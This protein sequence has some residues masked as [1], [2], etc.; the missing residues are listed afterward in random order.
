MSNSSK[1]QARMALQNIE[2]YSPGKPIWEV[3][4]ELG[5]TEVIKLASNENPLG[6]SPKAIQAA[7]ASL[8]DMHRYPDAQAYDL[9]HA[10]ADKLAMQSEQIIVTNGGDEL[11]TLLSEAYLEQGDEVIVP[12]PSF[13]EYEFGALLMGAATV[14]VPLQEGFQYDWRSIADA[15]TERTKIVYLCSPN[16][17]TGTYLTRTDLQQLLDRLPARVLVVMDAAYSHYVSASDYSD[18]L[19]FVRAGYP[20]LVLKTFS[21]IYGLAGIRV[22]F[23]VAGQDMIRNILQVKEPFNVN[24]MAQTAAISALDDEE[25]VRQSQ[26]L[27]IRERLRLYE[28]FRRL[29]LPYTVSMSNFVL[30]ELG[31]DAESLYQ[32]LMAGGVIVRYGKGWGLPK[33]IRV[34]IGTAAENDTFISVLQG[35][36]AASSR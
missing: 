33:H 32:R 5:L 14:K 4:R 17:P 28:A 2:P 25:H 34:S 15:V 3:Q 1:V 36:L 18:G 29:G 11:I 12:D 19:E 20:V 24:A 23:G 10:I 21:K 6:T 13:T 7:A 30:V 22:G 35:V 8:H 26:E 27:V 16:N 31:P 9:K